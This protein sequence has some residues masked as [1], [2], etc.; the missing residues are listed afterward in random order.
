M[1]LQ[2]KVSLNNITRMDSKSKRYSQFGGGD[3]GLFRSLQLAGSS[4]GITTEF[5]YGIYDGP[6][7]L[8]V[9]A[10]V[11]IENT[12]D[13]ANFQRAAL[14]GRYYVWLLEILYTQLI[15]IEIISVLP[16]YTNI[17]HIF[18]LYNF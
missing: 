2:L 18:I 3:H 6:E 14:S 17:F 4:F 9:I 5:H 7:V 16:N 11:Y 1:F 12:K 10:F 8:P 13:L 15:E